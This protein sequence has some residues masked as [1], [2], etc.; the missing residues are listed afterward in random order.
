MYLLYI[1]LRH[2]LKNN[3]FDFYLIFQFLAKTNLA[4]LYVFVTQTKN[5]PLVNFKNG[6]KYSC[7]AC[8]KVFGPKQ[9][10]KNHFQWPNSNNLGSIPDGSIKIL[11]VN[12]KTLNIFLLLQ[13]LHIIPLI[14][15]SFLHQLKL[16]LQK[17][18]SFYLLFLGPYWYCTF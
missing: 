4:P 13:I 18:F 8:V 1:Q 11:K 5:L 14:N 3:S 15:F 9:M 2:Q 7:Y 10:L 17:I 6:L 16:K 12:L